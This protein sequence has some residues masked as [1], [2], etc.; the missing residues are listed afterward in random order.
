[1]TGEN[2]KSD[3]AQDALDSVEKM[4]RS[5]FRRAIP[6][7]W[8]GIGISLIVAIGF[9][10]YALEDP[11]SF[12]GLF[13]ALGI[14]LFVGFSRERIGVFGK[15]LPDTKAGVWAMAGICA[16]LIALFFGGIIVRRAYDIAWVPLVTGLIAGITIF[17][18]SESERRFYFKKA[19][20]GTR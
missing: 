4:T 12:P 2:I 1:M 19:G 20:D 14:A 5:G 10:L 15:E 17:L 16:F 7:R 18:L 9:A 3:E 8:F 13:I 11:G 6:P